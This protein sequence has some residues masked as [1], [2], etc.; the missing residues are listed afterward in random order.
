MNEPLTLDRL[1]SVNRSRAARWDPAGKW[2]LADRAVE[3]AGEVGELCNVIKKLSR[4][5]DGMPGNKHSEAQLREMLAEEAADVLIT[6]D[7]VCN[8]AGIDLTSSTRRKFNATSERVGF[9]E[10]L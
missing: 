6:L 10:R 9:P 8:Q 7:L 2:D 3:M 4:A 1:R 5:R